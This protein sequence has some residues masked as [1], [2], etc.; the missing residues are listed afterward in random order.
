MLIADNTERK[1]DKVKEDNALAHLSDQLF[2][3]SERIQQVERKQ[4][5]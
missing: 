2:V 4:I 3:L 1:N 5:F